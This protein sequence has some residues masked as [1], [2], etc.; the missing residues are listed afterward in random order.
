MGNDTKSA[1]MSRRELL[2]LVGKV[3]GGGVM[4]G[5]MRSLGFAAES[6]FTGPIRLDG[7]PK[8][9]EILVLGA[10]LAG[11]VSALE[12]RNAGYKVK[13]L[14]F[15]ARA[16]GRA[17]TLRGGD[18][19]TEMGGATQHCAFDKGL[20][21]NPGPWRIP[22][23]HHGILDYARRF[24]VPLEPFIQTNYNAYVHAENAFG[25]K[26]QRYAHVRADY[27]GHVTELLAKA[28]NQGQLDAAL[29]K[30]DREILLE[31][32]RSWGALDKDFR[33]GANRN[34][35]ERR[36]FEVP[37]G[38]GLMPLPLPS[39]PIG[40]PELLK[41]G[42]WHHLSQSEELNHHT[43]MFQPVGGMDR[44]AQAIYNEVKPLV[45]LN[46]RVT[47]I[48][49]DARGVTVTYD[50]GGA[51][52]SVT[53][54]W[55]V[56][57]I[58]L[59][60]LS[61]IEVSASAPMIEAIQAVP[62]EASVKVGLQFKRRFWEQDDHI[63]G[64]VSYTSLPNRLISY[65]SC[66]YG[67]AGKG[68]LLGAYLFGP[69]AFETT[70][71]PPKDRVRMAL[72]FGAKVHPQYTK[73]FENG[74]A[75]AWHRVPFVQGCAGNWPLGAREKHYKNLCAIDGRLVL[76]G[77]HASTMFAWQEGAV[78]SALD[79]VQRLHAKIKATA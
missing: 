3:A 46:A 25:G 7:A 43:N 27:A 67:S 8:G 26:P 77:E 52:R 49:Q 5:A 76:A 41:S 74:I 19:F 65:P 35:S 28:T 15:N 48:E 73:E 42:L 71:L 69:N 63:F 6:H 10:G 31:S 47:R 1:S 2:A 4:Y 75:V 78:L 44:I 59:S 14:E 70:S 29:T 39:A 36:G 16:G 56:C 50:Q 23:H 13:V 11:L 45:Q 54:G 22:I 62:Y 12:L 32:L 40:L 55:C 68:V 66:D 61:Q 9:T 30:E 72:Q 60:I 53:A 18:T 20:Y 37:R 21:F 33:Y 58:P 17:W 38:G 34:T 64:G 79:A 57:T 51:T 24:K